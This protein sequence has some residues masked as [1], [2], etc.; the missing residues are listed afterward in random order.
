MKKIIQLEIENSEDFKNEII[1]GVVAQ[2][3]DLGI[4]NQTREENPNELI[5]RVET[6]KI[7]NISTVK[8]WQLT[9]DKLIDVCKIGRKTLYRRKAIND[10]INLQSRL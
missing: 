2:I 6:A 7:L 5:P 4:Y 1:R 8:L 9:K 10:F 3:K